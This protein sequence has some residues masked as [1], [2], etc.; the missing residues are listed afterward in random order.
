MRKKLRKL[1]ANLRSDDRNRKVAYASIA[2]IVGQFIQIV[3][4]LISVPLTL[5]Y[6]DSERFALWMLVTAL[7]S[8][9]YFADLGV[10]IG[11]QDRLTKAISRGDKNDIKKTVQI[12]CIFIFVIASF[13]MCTA[14]FAVP[15]ISWNNFFDL[16]SDLAK[17]EI[18]S[19]INAFIIT[20]AIGMVATIIQRIFIAFQETYI[21]AALV[22]VSKIISLFGLFIVVLFQGELWMLV[23]G[24]V[25]VGNFFLVICEFYL[26]Y[27]KRAWIFQYSKDIFDINKLNPLI[28]ILKN[29]IL[30]LGASLAFFIVNNSA[31]FV[32]TKKYGAESI[33]IYSLLI[34]LT[35]IATTV[36]TQLISPLWPALTDA[37]AK[38]EWNWVKSKYKQTIFFVIII[39]GFS[40]IIFSC[41]SGFIIKKWTGRH[42][43]DI[44]LYL[45]M[46]VLLMMVLG[47]W[48]VVLSVF[49]NGLSKFKSQATWGV[50]IA[51]T[52][53]LLA[54]FIPGKENLFIEIWIIALGY[55]A[56]CLAMHFEL[57]LSLKD[58]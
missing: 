26:L 48:N 32:L 39:S 1:L 3:T 33:I 55:F 50:W 15:L 17:K 47:Q 57:K 38:N 10:G 7:V 22:A 25:G 43:F 2:N 36:L 58:I 35:T 41:F 20:T 28:E 24:M 42:D 46:P 54:L 37:V 21:A 18:N 31:P 51:I 53:F 9:L 4:S 8:F 6:L 23:A 44:N 49:L 16:K 30:G 19:C 14:Y 13:I 29:G 56:R 27:R 34:K 40:I 11:M 52:A 45:I 12:S 5:S